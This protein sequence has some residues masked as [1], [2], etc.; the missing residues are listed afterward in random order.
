MELCDVVI[1]AS[2]LNLK[3]CSRLRHSAC[4]FNS[5]SSSAVTDRL[6]PVGQDKEEDLKNDFH[7]CINS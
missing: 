5:P 6:L 1:P 2:E 7:M 4:L 3:G